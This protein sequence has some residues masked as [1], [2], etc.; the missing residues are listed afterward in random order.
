MSLFSGD[1]ELLSR[2]KL[3]F[4]AAVEYEESLI[5]LFGNATN[6]SD[7]IRVAATMIFSILPVRSICNGRNCGSMCSYVCNTNVLH[8]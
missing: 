8:D 3:T 6:A 5:L 7:A 4:V 2:A 1:N